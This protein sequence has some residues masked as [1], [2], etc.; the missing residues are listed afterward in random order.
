MNEIA[1]IVPNWNGEAHLRRLFDSLQTQTVPPA[2]VLVVDNGS[3]DGS[4]ALARER[5]YDVLALAANA[6]FA[7]AVNRGIAATS[8]PFVAILNNDVTLASD[9]LERLIKALVTDFYPEAY[10]ATGKIYRHGSETVLDAGW[11]LL[12]RACLPL[13]AGHNR[14]DGPAWEQ[15]REIAFA[16]LTAALFRRELFDRVGNLDERFESYLEDVD[17]GL[18]CAVD[19]SRGRFVPGAYAWHWGSATLGVWHP[20]TIRLQSRN[21]LLLAAKHFPSKWFGSLGRPLLAGQLL[22]G[23]LAFRH[24]KLLPWIRG[25]VEALGLWSE[26]RRDRAGP[27]RVPVAALLSQFERE[28]LDL[29]RETGY[30]QFWL[31]YRRVAGDV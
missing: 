5:G 14:P 28:I 29:Q 30:D 7:P 15:P 17:L 13:R 27:G 3:S 4:V 6:G 20:E 21:Q 2:R 19:G 11:D 22:W 25:K 24:H 10:F 12:S 23:L 18:R 9:Y 26:Y 8:E 1:A 16:P 31:W